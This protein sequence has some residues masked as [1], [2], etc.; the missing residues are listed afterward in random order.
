L[1]IPQQSKSEK[2]G[3]IMAEWVIHRGAPDSTSSTPASWNSPLPDTFHATP[4]H[5]LK[6]T[7]GPDHKLASWQEFDR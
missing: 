1:G 6:L 3:S 4:S 7:F 2:D 5:H